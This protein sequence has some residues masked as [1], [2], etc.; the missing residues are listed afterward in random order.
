[1]GYVSA[2]GRKPPC[3]NSLGR[4]FF[5]I[6]GGSQKLGDFSRKRIA[7]PVLNAKRQSLFGSNTQKEMA[8]LRPD[9]FP[10]A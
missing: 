10:A 7:T 4:A 2:S 1:M 8:Y 6:M 3:M 5:W 9:R